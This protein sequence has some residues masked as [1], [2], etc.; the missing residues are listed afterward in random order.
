MIADQAIREAA[1]VLWPASRS[2]IDE[3]QVI[4]RRR[5]EGSRSYDPAH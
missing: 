3:K 5:L 4:R 1:R 2:D